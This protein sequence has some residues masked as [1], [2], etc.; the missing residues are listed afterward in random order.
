MKPFT[1]T[2][3]DLDRAIDEVRSL[4]EEWPAAHREGGP[5]NETLQCVCLVLHE[6]IANLH[7]HAQFP[8]APPTVEIRLSCEDRHVFC[9]VVDNSEGFDV[10]EY[11]PDDDEDLETL[12]ERGMGLR[13]IKTCTGSL[14]YTPTED[15]LHSFEFN[16]PSDHDPWLN[17]LF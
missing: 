16:I 15:G 13:M 11:L 4:P 7:Q 3:T 5:D 9:S 12:P 8:S 2:Y 17:T 1:K 6:W 10:E 14:S